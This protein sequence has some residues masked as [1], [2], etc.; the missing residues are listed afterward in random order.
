[1]RRAPAGLLVLVIALAGCGG[2]DDPTI[3]VAA[4]SSLTG[5]FTDCLAKIQ[6]VKAVGEYGGS[7]DLA[8]QIKQGVALDVFAAAN[9]KLPEQLAAAGQVQKP[10][11]FATNEL[12]LAV[13][14]GTGPITTFDDLAR[15]PGTKL[16][17]GAASVPVGSYTRQVLDRLP[18][19]QAAAIKK[20]IRTE[21]P[22]V[23]SIVGKLTTGAVDAGFVYR[24]DVLAAGDELRIVRL[25][26]ALQP[27][28][29]YGLAAVRPG[30][31]AQK[32]ITDILSGGC[33]KALQQAGFG[34][35]GE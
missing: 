16:A 2:S 27:T 5:A 23:K 14:A 10:V 8:E 20:E 11:P 33:H 30:K 35:P 9:T 26:A 4:A 29:V 19:A 34:T 3:K 1:M 24:T 15:T 6:G 18:P 12:V 13:P 17:V 32:V 21:E 31:G 22:D 28:V 7:D 25:P